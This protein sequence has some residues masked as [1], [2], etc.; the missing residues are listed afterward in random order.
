MWQFLGTVSSVRT[1]QYLFGIRT[2]VGGVNGFYGLTEGLSDTLPHLFG[3]QFERGE[4]GG[5]FLAP[6]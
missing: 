6:F 4:G 2:R 1:R 3:L 5:Y